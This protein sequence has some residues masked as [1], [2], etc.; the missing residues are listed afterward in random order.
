MSVLSSVNLLMM[1]EDNDDNSV[2]LYN[3]RNMCNNF[4]DLQKTKQ[5]QK[6]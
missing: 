1:M 2:N 4:K 3:N 5:I 6:K